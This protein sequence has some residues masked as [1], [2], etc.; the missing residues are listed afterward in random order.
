M[1]QTECL[2]WGLVRSEQKLLFWKAVVCVSLLSV[3]VYKCCSVVY[4]KILK[5]SIHSNTHKAHI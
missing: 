1:K 3:T 5:E 4:W 2:I